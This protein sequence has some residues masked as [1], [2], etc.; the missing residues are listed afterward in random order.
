MV[1]SLSPLVFAQFVEHHVP[2]VIQ[3]FSKLHRIDQG[4]ASP[5]VAVVPVQIMAAD[6]KRGNPPAV[7]PDPDPVQP[8]A[9]A[10]QKCALEQIGHFD[11]TFQRDLTSFQMI[12]FFGE[13]R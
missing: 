3:R 1:I 2:Q 7:V 11:G 8:G 12:D 10:Q 4:P 5:V 6:Q 13:M 9:H